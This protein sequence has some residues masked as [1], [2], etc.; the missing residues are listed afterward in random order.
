VCSI[1][2]CVIA[3]GQHA[4][5][6]TPAGQHVQVEI[7]AVAVRTPDTHKLCVNAFSLRKHRF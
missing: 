3:Q 1:C 2:L 7:P 5:V 4:T 6:A